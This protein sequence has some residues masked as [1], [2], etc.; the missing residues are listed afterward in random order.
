MH[1]E[2]LAIRLSQHRTAEGFTFDCQTIAGEVDVLQV[3]VNGFDGFPIFITQT[4]SQII[5]I[6]Y[7][8]TEAEVNPDFRLEMMEM[9]LDTSMSI[10]LS[11][12]GRVSDR[13]VLYGAL[14]VNSS[15]DKLVEEIV[16]LNE[17]GIDVVTAMED[18]LL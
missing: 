17:N 12:Y 7:M 11:S 5:C 1:I 14:S 13:Y 2:D 3:E 16:T 6:I 18:F 10:P 4:N 8:W 15:F 9:M